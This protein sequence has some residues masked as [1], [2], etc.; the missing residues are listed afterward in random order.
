MELEAGQSSLP[1]SSPQDL[2]NQIPCQAS[3]KE[4]V[5][6]SKAEIQNIPKG[7]EEHRLLVFCGPCSIHNTSGV[8]DYTQRLAELASEVREDILLVI[9]TDFEK[10]RSMVGWKGPLYD[11][12]L[13]G[14]SDSVG[15][16]CVARRI[17]ASIAKLSLRCTT[18]FLNPMLPPFQKVYSL[19]ECIWA[20]AVERRIDREVASGLDMPIG[21]KNNLVGDAL[22]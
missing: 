8:F 6:S 2:E 11:R 20:G 3:V 9:R 13:E 12:E 14:S 7:L 4:L 5:F 19:N 21:M 1:I 22:S 17:F 18:E 10:P 15:E 16:L